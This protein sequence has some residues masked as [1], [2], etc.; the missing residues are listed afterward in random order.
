MG[1]VAL[2]RTLRISADW[3][4]KGNRL[5]IMFALKVN[6]PKVGMA[7][8]TQCSRGIVDVDTWHKLIGHV[9]LQR[10]KFMQMQ[11]IVIDLPNFK[12]S[13]MQKV[14]EACQ[15]GK[16][17]LEACIYKRKECEW[18]DIK[19]CTFKCVGTYKDN[20]SCRS[21]LVCDIH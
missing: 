9:N 7:M 18:K 17:W 5:R 8:Y 4:A 6:M 21:Q 2:L 10:L 16:Q 12:M 13:H 1:M 15:F 14:C 20:I 19:N 11:G 3:I